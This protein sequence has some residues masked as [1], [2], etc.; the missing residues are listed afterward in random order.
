MSS[1]SRWMPVFLLTA[2][3]LFLGGYANAA[4]VA[5]W[6]FNGGTTGATIATTT[7][8]VGN[9]QFVPHIGNSDDPVFAEDNDANTAAG[10]S[11]IDGVLIAPNTVG[12]LAGA[13][14]LNISFDVDLAENKESGTSA[15]VRMGHS[16]IAF[17]VYFQSDNIIGIEMEGASGS[18]VIR[19]LGSAIDADAGWQNVTVNWDG[20][21]VEILVDDTPQIFTTGVDVHPFAIGALLSADAR[22]GLGGLVRSND[23]VGQFFE[24]SIDNLIISDTSTTINVPTLGG[25][26]NDDGVVDAADYTVW[27]D[28]LGAAD[29]SSLNGNGDGAN[30]VDSADYTLWVANFGMESTTATVAIP[31]P[32]SLLLVLA[33]LMCAGTKCCRC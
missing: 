21:F 6:D 32:S 20:S 30:G 24:G 13:T 28:N 10:F 9:R 1:I 26:Y 19:T 3:G 22:L 2:V 14:E 4:V 5:S 33:G 27:R 11:G 7:D 29:E 15:I 31:E 8:S 17:N 12:F 25:D 23:T 18:G 16:D